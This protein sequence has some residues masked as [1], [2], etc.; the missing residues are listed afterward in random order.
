MSAIREFGGDP[1]RMACVERVLDISA[2]R[3]PV[4]PNVDFALGALSYVADLPPTAP[5]V[6]FSIARLAGMIAHV[7]EE[8]A[9]PP[10]RYRT[11]AR[12]VGSAQRAP[13]PPVEEL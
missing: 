12:Y 6:M 11:T 13:R 9:A 3:L 5:A 1:S 10:L 7:L 8:Y 4:A 2:M